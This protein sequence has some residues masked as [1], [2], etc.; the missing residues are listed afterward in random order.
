MLV[1]MYIGKA[2][3]MPLLIIFE[4]IKRQIGMDGR[5][6]GPSCGYGNWNGLGMCTPTCWIA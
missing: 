3:D 5:G 4:M 1:I 2:L 6:Y